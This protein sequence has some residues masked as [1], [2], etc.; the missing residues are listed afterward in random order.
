MSESRRD[1]SRVSKTLII[2]SA[3]LKICSDTTFQ[4]RL[5]NKWLPAETWVE[6]LAK[7]NLIDHALMSSIKVGAFNPAMGRSGG[8]FDGQ[9]ISRYDGTNVTGIFRLIFQRATFYIK[10]DKNKQVSYPMPLGDSWKEGVMDVAKNVFCL[11]A[12]RSS[13]TPQ[14]LMELHSD[15]PAASSKRQR[16][17]DY[18][19]AYGT[20]APHHIVLSPT[21]QQEITSRAPVC[22]D[23]GASSSA[24]VETNL[25]AVSNTSFP[26]LGSYWNSR[27][28]F[29]LFGGGL[30]VGSPL[31]DV[32]DLLKTRV[33][34]LQS[35]NRGESGGETLFKV[36]T[37]K[38]SA[39]Q[40]ISLRFEVDQ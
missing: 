30:Q 10:T 1:K 36:G 31:D 32:R 15:E 22:M 6:V 39:H 17:D 14:G 4:R 13:S 3:F 20:V 25:E 28:A 26:F 7:S 8:D 34:L 24:G 2:R 23:P 35:V 33:E 19:D 5:W 18:E 40:Q 16:T 29:N 27:D 38:I 9:M 12:T 21:E 11:R 37:Q